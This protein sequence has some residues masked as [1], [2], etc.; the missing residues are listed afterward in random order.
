MMASYVDDEAQINAEFQL[1]SDFFDEMKRDFFADDPAFS[2]RSWGMSHDYP[3]AI[4]HHS[5]M[6]RI[7]TAIFG[8]RVY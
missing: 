8:E 3:L 1:A 4:R 2:Q 5:T 6:V 7:G